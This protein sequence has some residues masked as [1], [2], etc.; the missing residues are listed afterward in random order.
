MNTQTIAELQNSWTADVML[1]NG[2]IIT[3]W[4]TAWASIKHTVKEVVS[5]SSDYPRHK[6]VSH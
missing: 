5:I 6:I 3:I 2:K 4:H 1:N